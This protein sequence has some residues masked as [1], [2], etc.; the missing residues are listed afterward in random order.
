MLQ[1]TVSR[2]I[3]VAPLPGRGRALDAEWTRLSGNAIPSG[4]MQRV[5]SSVTGLLNFLVRTHSIEVAQVSPGFGIRGSKR[6]K[7]FIFQEYIR[8]RVLRYKKYA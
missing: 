4:Y 1:A 3:I 6:Q 5:S 2:V 7:L 8:L